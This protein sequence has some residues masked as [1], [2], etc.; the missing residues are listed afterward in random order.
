MGL[1]FTSHLRES[2]S[3]MLSTLFDEARPLA[4][5]EERSML[6][7]GFPSSAKFNKKKAESKANVERM[8]EA[9]GSI[10]GQRL[11]PTYELIDGPNDDA[12]PE[13]SAEISEDELVDLVKDSFDANEVVPS[14]VV[15]DD[16][17]ESGTG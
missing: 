16:A 17:R 12:A 13:E 15:P 6:R 7:I 14:E 10:A 5:D 8:T 3:A 1:F 2:G 4:I 11:R 9:L